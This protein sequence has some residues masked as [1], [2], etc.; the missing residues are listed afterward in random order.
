M[1]LLTTVTYL[2]NRSPRAETHFGP[3]ETRLEQNA[4]ARLK[5]LYKH[6][7]QLAMKM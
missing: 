6:A 3:D 2:F 7:G 5:S 1:Q 4:Q